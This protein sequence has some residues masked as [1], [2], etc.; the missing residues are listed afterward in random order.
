MLNYH[1]KTLQLL[2]SEPLC[3]Q[4]PAYN[5][6][7]WAKSNDIILPTAFLEWAELNGQQ[8]L[9][10]YSNDDWFYFNEEEPVINTTPEGLKGILFHTENQGNFHQIVLLN[11]GENPPVLYS[12]IGE[13]PWIVYTQRFSDCIFAQIFDW[14]YWLEFDNEDPDY[15]EIAYTGEINLKTDNCLNI[16][17]DRFKEEVSTQYVVDVGDGN[18]FEEIKE[19]RF[20]ISLDTRLT[21]TVGKLDEDCR[22]NIRITG[23]YEPVVALEAE[24]LRVFDENIP[25]T[26][27]SINEAV[28]SLGAKIDSECVEQLK[29]S[30][31]EIP[32]KKAIDCLKN[33]HQFLSLPDRVK[34][35]GYPQ[36][37]TDDRS[38]FMIGGSDWG[39]VIHFQRKQK[40]RGRWWIKRIFEI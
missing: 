13:P 17:R 30:C 21:V 34:Q 25:P 22:A 26:Y 40:N 37:P 24:L 4:T 8:V 27:I 35:M 39:V 9:S 12:W 7:K 11:F 33:C 3:R 2:K 31:L 14:Q 28:S 36:F 20:L 15:K 32:S 19:Y 5:L 38:N 10:K 1:H 6:R 23:K 29:Y 16:L 18:K